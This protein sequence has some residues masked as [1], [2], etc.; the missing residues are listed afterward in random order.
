MSNDY[1]NRGHARLLSGDVKAATDDYI[2]A[3]RK[4]NTAFLQKTMTLDRDMLVA[5]GADAD[6]L[7]FIV[8]RSR[9]NDNDF[10]NM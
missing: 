4:S 9:F 7:T 8:E 6:L 3:A 2:T 10:E 1:V 5:A